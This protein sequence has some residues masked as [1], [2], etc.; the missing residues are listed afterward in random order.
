MKTDK[1]LDILIAKAHKEIFQFS[2]N[3]YLYSVDDLIE[4]GLGA[5]IPHLIKLNKQVEKVTVRN[6]AGYP[7]LHVKFKTNKKSKSL[8]S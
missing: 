4:Y 1:S 7:L 2:Y 5:K 6:M 3:K 8:S